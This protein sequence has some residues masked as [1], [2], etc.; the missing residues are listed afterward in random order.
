M[1]ILILGANGQLGRIIF[2]ALRKHFPQAE[3]LAAV[4]SKHLH[5][6]GVAGDHL[7]HS[8]I[9]DPLQSDWSVF[10]K[11]DC[12]INC[13]GAIDETENSFE[14]VHILPL[15]NLSSQF[16]ILGRPRLIQVS[17]LG[18]RPD[19]TSAFMRTKAIA[20]KLVLRLPKACV[21]RPSVVC[22]Q[23]TRMVRAISKLKKLARI[24]SG[25]ILFPQQALQTEIQPV[26]PEDLAALIVALVR[27]ETEERIIEITGAE[28]ICIGELL[29]IA[30]LHPVP[31]SEKTGRIV[32][33]IFAPLVKRML[34]KEQFLLLHENN[35]AVNRLAASIIGRNLMPTRLFWEKELAG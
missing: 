15:L 26:A 7:Q 10:G 18:A 3:I 14:T 16:E 4:R 35:T 20:E 32:M 31:V 8:V 23:G 29:G 5:F 6:E 17:A 11:T 12:I 21:V 2:D 25:R 34:S 22:T 33:R 24:F 30:S 27:S 9:F 1:R 13:I 19:S 28:K